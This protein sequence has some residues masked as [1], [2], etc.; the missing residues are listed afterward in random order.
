MYVLSRSIKEL[1]VKIKD[2]ENKAI[3]EG[4]NVTVEEIA[5]ELKVEKCIE[6]GACSYICPSKLGLRDAVKMAKKKVK[7]K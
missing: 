1:C 4:K 6:C 3:K 5:K 7:N 2:I